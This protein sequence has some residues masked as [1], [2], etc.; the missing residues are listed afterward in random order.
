MTALRT[1][2]MVVATIASLLVAAFAWPVVVA[3]VS[4]RCVRSRHEGA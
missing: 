2:G 1:A 3:V 4:N